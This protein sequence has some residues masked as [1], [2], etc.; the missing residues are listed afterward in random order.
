V[1]PAVVGVE[2]AAAVEIALQ[3][4]VWSRTRRYVP[5]L[6]SGPARSP[7]VRGHCGWCGR[8]GTTVTT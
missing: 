8:R 6:L 1:V 4:R 2:A 3:L 7:Q 5:R